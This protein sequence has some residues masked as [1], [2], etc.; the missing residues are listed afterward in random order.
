MERIAFLPFGYLMDKW[1][2]GVYGGEI[3][4][5]E[6]N[7][8]WWELRLKYQGIKPLNIRGEE[9]FDPGAKYHI[10]ADTSYIR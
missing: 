3:K 8:K 2:W 4:S 1:M 9:F 7:K 10:P 6:Y 5:S